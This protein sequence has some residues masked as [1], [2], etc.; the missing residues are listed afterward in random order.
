MEDTNCT[1][2]DACNGVS[3]NAPDH[4]HYGP[5]CAKQLMF[6]SKRQSSREISA[7]AHMKMLKKS[8][9]RGRTASF[10]DWPSYCASHLSVSRNIWQ[11]ITARVVVNLCADFTRVAFQIASRSVMNFRGMVTFARRVAGQS[12]LTHGFTAV[13]P[14]V[15]AIY[16]T[17]I[18]S[19]ALTFAVA[20]SNP[21]CAQTREKGMPSPP[22]YVDYAIRGKVFRVPE[23]YLDVPPSRDQLGHLNTRQQA[24][25]FAFWLSD[26]KPSPVRVLSLTTHW[27]KAAG[28][29]TSGD[30]DFIVAVRR[31]TYLP[32]GAEK[33]IVLPAQQ[34]RN[35]LQTYNF[36][37]QNRTEDI[38]YGL[39]CY[40]T[41]VPTQHSL[42]CT[43]PPG[44]DPDVVLKSSWDR[45][46][47]APEGPPNPTWG[48]EIFSREDGLSI[49]LTFP[50][51]A[52]RRWS[53]VVCQTLTLIRSWEV[54]SKRSGAGCSA[55]RTA[56]KR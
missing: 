10:T 15:D 55:Q 49:F 28:R 21:L 43:T 34:V 42:L 11:R 30:Q 47:H 16:P 1:A 53:D 20:L 14:S 48:T 29:P 33:E 40:R 3:G 37:E 36:L 5:L 13:M 18:P 4:T 27:P 9:L 52:L 7:V 41:R 19:V 6:R 22:A 35:T 12:C 51:I 25:G 26:L 23:P 17:I 50:E 45:R 2:P 56:A 32:P 46:H 54:P 39:T 24:F 44:A 8:L 31:V 38:T